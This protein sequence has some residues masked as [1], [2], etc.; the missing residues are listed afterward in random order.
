MIKI[1]KAFFHGGSSLLSKY[2]INK[3]LNDYD[4][5]Y[6]FC[7]DKLKTEKI[8]EIE[9]LPDNKKF[10]FFEND[11]NDLNKTLED[12]RKLPNDFSGIFW[13]TGFTGNPDLEYEEYEH[14]IRNI[15]INFLNPTICISELSKKMVYN[16]N[17]FICV[18]TSVAGLRGRGK[19]LYYSASKSG[20]INFLSG[21]RQK[22][23]KKITVHTIIPG[24]ISTNSFSENGPKFLISSP[25]KSAEIIY[26]GIKNKK[27]IIYVNNLWKII[28]FLLFLFP[29][30]IFKKFSF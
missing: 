25:E 18:I 28:M 13:V 7:R 17:S 3:F 15:S 5:F 22:F 27:E 26:N 12:I 9:K 14:A 8:I 10:I 19:R 16:E 11:L 1:R 30:K 2:L 4:E 24:Y 6:I 21:L 20:L 23:N 29:E